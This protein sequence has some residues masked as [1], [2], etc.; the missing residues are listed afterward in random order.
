VIG[1]RTLKSRWKARL[2]TIGVVTA[3][4]KLTMFALYEDMHEDGSRLTTASTSD[5]TPVMI[6]A[7]TAGSIKHDPSHWNETARP[8][9]S[10]LAGEGVRCSS[11]AIAG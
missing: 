2:F 10:V 4:V 6:A 7:I 3:T 5:S 8:Y 11:D 1:R 9:S